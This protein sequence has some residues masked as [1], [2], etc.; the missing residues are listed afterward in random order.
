MARTAEPA[1][2]EPSH[3]TQL[4][5]TL[6][7]PTASTGTMVPAADKAKR[8]IVG[9]VLLTVVMVALLAAGQAID[10]GVY[11]LSIRALNADKH[12]SVFGLASLLAQTVVAVVSV[13]RGSRV[14]RAR[15][16]WF[17]LGALLAGL[18]VFRGLT[19]FNATALALPLLGVLGL[20]CWLTWSDR[21]AGRALIWAGLVF[22]ATSLVLHKVGLAADSSLASDYT[23]AYQI[24]G[25]VKHGSE[26]AGWMLLAIGIVAGIADRPAAELIPGGISRRVAASSRGLARRSRA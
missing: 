3:M 23:W 8:I 11:N 22:M 20:V 19:T 1:I 2:C 18:V 16:A 24:E 10:F 17:T 5:S 4:S 14:E 7:R 15:W 6:E 26:L 21:A 25:I 9:G 12:A 13:W